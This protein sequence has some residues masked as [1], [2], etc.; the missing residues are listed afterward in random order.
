M[1]LLSTELL[2]RA[3]GLLALALTVAGLLRQCDQGLRRS[4]GTASALWGLHNLLLGAHTAA[5]LCVLILLRQFGAHRLAAA[6]QRVRILACAGFMAAMMLVGILTWHG[7]PSI[8]TTTGSMLATYAMFRLRGAW[9][10]GAMALVALLW[11]A[12]SLHFQAWEQLAANLITGAAAAAGA[13][14]AWRQ[15]RGTPGD[16]PPDVL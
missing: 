8:F 11:M 2:L 3:T 12:N 14:A 7:A 13:A 6:G 10:R 1:S 16:L 9:L 5:A 4:T 15:Q